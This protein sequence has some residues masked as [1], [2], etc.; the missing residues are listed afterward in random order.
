MCL[1]LL[2]DVIIIIIVVVIIIMNINIITPLFY[3]YWFLIELINNRILYSGILR[4]PLS[5]QGS[6]NLAKDKY[7]HIFLIYYSVEGTPLFRAKGHFFWVSNPGFNLYSGD[8]LVLR[9]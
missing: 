5:I 1:T 7:S 2:N 4:T 6:Q 9:T 3:T 8:S